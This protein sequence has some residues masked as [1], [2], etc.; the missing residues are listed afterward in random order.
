[1][2]H[3][4]VG[5]VTYEGRDMEYEWA[6]GLSKGVHVRRSAWPIGD[7]IVEIFSG[8]IGYH[9]TRC[10]QGRSSCSFCT[11]LHEQSLCLHV[12]TVDLL[13]EVPS[14]H[15]PTLGDLPQGQRSQVG[16]RYLFESWTPSYDALGLP[17]EE[18]CKSSYERV[19][20]L[21]FL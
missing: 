18:P 4:D 16:A 10:R 13:G 1:M 21:P 15:R 12:I 6:E 9:P 17:R 3:L 8:E 11:S 20:S 2:G 19:Q 14:R 5:Q 7:T